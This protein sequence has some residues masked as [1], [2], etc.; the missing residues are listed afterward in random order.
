M[1]IT[2]SL[3]VF[4]KQVGRGVKA[5]VA[6]PVTVMRGVLPNQAR[7]PLLRCAMPVTMWLY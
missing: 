5:A 6:M 3:R 4:G 2:N 1:Q 7:I